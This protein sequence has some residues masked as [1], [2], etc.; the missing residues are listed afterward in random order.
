[1]INAGRGPGK[2]WTCHD[3]VLIISV[4]V[5]GGIVLVCKDYNI[6]TKLNALEYHR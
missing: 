1:M 5:E 6:Y 4:S 3:D 2:H